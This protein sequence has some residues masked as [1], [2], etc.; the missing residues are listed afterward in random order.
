MRNKGNRRLLAGLITVALSITE[1]LGYL[2]VYAADPEEEYSL[3]NTVVSSWE[4]GYQGELLLRNLSDREM[5]EWSINFASANRIS[6]YWGASFCLMDSVDNETPEDYNQEYHYTVEAIDYTGTIAPGEEITIGYIADGTVGESAELSVEY[7]LKDPNSAEGEDSED[8]ESDKDEN[9]EGQQ[10]P[11][12]TSEP[13]GGIYVGD[14]YKVEVQI[15]Q[16]WDHAYNVKLL[17]TN[18]KEETLHNWGFLMNTAD[19][20]SGLYNAVELSEHNGTRL[21]KNAGYNQDIPAGGT[22]EVGYTAFYEESPVVPDEFALAS[23][24]KSV[25]QTEYSVELFVLDEWDGGAVAE[26]VIEN[27]SEQSIEDWEMEFDTDTAILGIWGGVIISHEGTHYNL[28]NADYAQN[29]SPGELWTIGLEITGSVSE[30]ENVFMRKIVVA[31]SE[32]TAEIDDKKDTDGDG[33]PDVYEEL[34]ETDPEKADTDGDLLSDYDELFLTGTDPCKYDSVRTGISDFDADSDEDGLSNGYEL[35]AGIDPLNEDSDYDRLSDGEEVNLYHTDPQEP[36]SDGDTLSDGEEVLIGLDPLNPATNG[37]PDA[38]YIIEQTIGS[39]SD[40][41]RLINGKETAYSLSLTVKAAGYAGNMAVG[42]SGYGHVLNNASVIG[43][44]P[45][46]EY[47]NKLEEMTIS[48]K[49]NDSLVDNILGT[50]AAYNEE[51]RGI[52]RLSIAYYSEE[53]QVCLPIESQY[54]IENHIVYATVSRQ[55]TYCLID[56]EKW[57]DML[58]FEPEDFAAEED[59][60]SDDPD[61]SNSDIYG[62]LGDSDYEKMFFGGHLYSLIPLEMT[63]DAAEE[64]CEGRGGHLATIT[65]AA[66]QRFIRE[67][68]LDGTEDFEYCWLGGYTKDSLDDF[69]WITGEPFEYTNWRHGEPNFSYEKCLHVYNTNDPDYFGLWNNTGASLKQYFI[70]EWDSAENEEPL[71]FFAVTLNP[72]PDDFGPITSDNVADYDGDGVPNNQEIRFSLDLGSSLGTSNSM[73]DLYSYFEVTTGLRCFSSLGNNSERVMS[74]LQDVYLVMINSDPTSADSDGD[75]ITDGQSGYVYKDKNEIK[76]LDNQPLTKGVCVNGEVVVGELTI[77]SCDNGFGGHAFLV[78]QSYID[79][80]LDFSG[81]T[82]GYS[83]GNW[84]PEK[85]GLYEIRSFEYVSIGNAGGQAG[86]SSSE[87]SESSA[88]GNDHDIAGIYY[89]REFAN[90]YHHYHKTFNP[91]YPENYRAKYDKNIAYSCIITK[92]QL[93]DLIYYSSQNNYYN[94]AFNNC[95]EVASR[96][97]NYIMPETEKIPESGLPGIEKNLLNQKEG[98][99][100]FDMYQIVS[101]D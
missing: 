10:S 42:E 35:G 9:N 63:W 67:N 24:E 2:P 84:E 59:N 50:Y 52:K 74:K 57:F 38:E 41:L 15:P 86:G 66:E 87:S 51:L 31:E 55:G 80:V 100:V 46:F 20:I 3:E 68:L 17:I 37:V 21:L 27:T 92:L 39:D 94:V 40:T 76:G 30:I 12:Q 1:V 18:T 70:C 26:I 56:L 11:E 44:I 23:F 6:D 93:N 29:I 8:N 64:Y 7:V 60:A 75:G 71:M 89:N 45:S 16:T 90:E 88:T 82:S 33:I 72:V 58:G 19:V 61:E 49:I 48:F 79:D 47:E 78:Y 98:S 14:G 91:L 101:R 99:F 5:T 97:W 54:D 22:V 4:G 36:D 69:E 43:M 73:L 95:V 25:E 65:S 77:V 96:S 83:Y 28:R 62:D 53:L 13:A 34:F 81:L 85:A 32:Q